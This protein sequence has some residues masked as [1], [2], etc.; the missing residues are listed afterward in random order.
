MGKTRKILGI[1]MIVGA[2]FMAD[3]A[4]AQ[5]KTNVYTDASMIWS[6]MACNVDRGLVRQGPEW[7]GDVLYTVQ[8][9]KIFQ[10]FSS[11]GFDLAYTYKDGKLY[12]GESQFSDAI[13]YTFEKG[14]IYIGD[15]TYPLDLAY[16]VRANPNYRGVLSV[17]YED[18][19]SPLDIVAFLQGNPTEVEVFAILVAI[20]LL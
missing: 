8:E 3:N 16:T 4:V 20:S 17:Y 13:S 7:R 19:I 6:Q 9:E 11:S 12:M 15:S 10:G 2:F 1:L 5:T 18:S 14:K